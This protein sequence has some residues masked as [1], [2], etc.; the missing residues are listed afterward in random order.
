[1]PSISTPTHIDPVHDTEFLYH[2]FSSYLRSHFPYKVQKISINAGLSCPNRDGTLG[3]GGCI[4]CNNYSFAPEYTHRRESIRRQLEEGIS[5]FARKYP[6]MKYLAYFQAYTN[7]Y[8]DTRRLI[9]MYEEALTTPGVVGLVIGTRPDCL[10]ED[11]RVY[12]KELA[13]HQFVYMEYGLESTLDSTLERIN[14][15]HT[16]EQCKEVVEWSRTSGIDCGVHLILGLPGEK[17]EDYLSHADKVSDLPITSLKIHQ[18]QVLEGTPLATLYREDP[19]ILKLSD[20]KDY[21]RLLGEF[22]M[23]L[24]PD[25]YLDRFVS[26]SPPELLLA[27]KWNIK[28]YQF[29]EQL[30]RYMREEGIYQGKDYRR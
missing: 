25:I 15:G 23:R 13:S 30:K 5:F 24:R 27:P 29:T 20:P 6:S 22:V 12:L 14:R 10:G 17:W 3:R 4:Y 21:I 8:G 26:Q 9:R 11:L 28:N 2:D 18:L 19:S 1:M 16:F 7:T